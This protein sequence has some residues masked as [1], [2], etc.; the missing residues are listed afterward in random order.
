MVT[1]RFLAAL[2]FPGVLAAANQAVHPMHTTFTEIAQPA[3]RGEVTVTIRGFEDDL[4]AAARGK[5]SGITDSS[6]TRYL[7]RQTLLT[8]RN[9][10]AIPLVTAGIRRRAGVLWLTLRSGRG[11]DLAGSRFINRTL[12]EVFHDQVN[13]VQ[14]KMAGRHRTLMFVPGDQP[15]PI[16]G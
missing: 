4:T 10:R 13:L 7:R 2:I 3:A 6:I 14:V 15:K 12:T 9:G 5:T 1:S 8:D 11:I 16:G